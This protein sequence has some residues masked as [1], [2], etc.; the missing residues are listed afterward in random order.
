M[1]DEQ[2]MPMFEN[3][4]DLM[5]QMR[6]VFNIYK[7]LIFQTFR[8]SLPRNETCTMDFLHNLFK[9]KKQRW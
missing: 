7:I 3:K 4:N 8:V 9:K 2:T 1:Y 5:N 6:K